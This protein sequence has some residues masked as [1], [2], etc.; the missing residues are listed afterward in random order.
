MVWFEKIWDYLRKHFP[1]DLSVIEGLTV[2]PVTID[3]EEV[4]IKLHCGAAAVMAEF[5]G[6][7]LESAVRTA[8]SKI[9]VN[10]VDS[11]PRF[12][13]HHPA[14]LGHYF[15]S[16]TV[17]GV[18]KL[19]ISMFED[20][21]DEL[22][23]L[24]EVHLSGEDRSQMRK[25]LSRA[26][27]S[28][29]T[30]ENT[31]FLSKLPIF[32]K[33]SAIKSPKSVEYTSVSQTNLAVSCDLP[34]VPI[35]QSFLDLSSLN[36]RNLASLLKIN[37]ITLTQLL[38]NIVFPDV[39]SA[40]YDADELRKL[41]TFV[42]KQY[43]SC[44]QED[45]DF[46]QTLRELAFLPK[47]DGLLVTPDRLYDPDSPLLQDLFLGE[48]NFPDDEYADAS[49]LAVLREIGL[50]DS[51]CI[52]IYDLLFTAI[53]IDNMVKSGSLA[54]EKLSRKVNSFV[55][56]LSTETHYLEEI[57]DEKTLGEML[58]GYCWVPRLHCKPY[59]Y[60]TSLKWFEDD[61]NYFKPNE[62][63]T[64]DNC[65]LV[66]AVMPVMSTSLP[67]KFLHIFQWDELPPLTL[68][69]QHLKMATNCYIAKEKGK[70]MS[71]V[72]NIYSAFCHYGCEQV[73]NEL[74]SQRID[75]WI[76]HGDGFASLQN[77]VFDKTFTDLRPY[78]FSLPEE[79]ESFSNLFTQFGVKR[80]ADL[81]KVL[82]MIKLKNESHQSVPGIEIKRDL[83][84]CVS[85]LND[86]KS[87]LDQNELDEIRNELL[88][89]LHDDNQT[90][91]TLA[92]MHE[93]TYCDTEWLRQGHDVA[94]FENEEAIK[95]VHPNI[96]NATSESLGVPTLMSRMLDAEELDFSFGQSDSLTHRLN[97]LLQ[98]YT[99]G[100]AIPK[101][102]LQN[103]DD[104]GATELK[105]LYD[106]RQN[107]NARTFLIDE[108]MAECQGPA[109]WAY[110][111]AVFTDNDFENITK[112]SGATKES[113]IE[114]IG[115]FGL[116]FN[117]VYNIT[118]V[119]S[120]VSRNNIV[121]FD[122]HTTHLGKGIK[123]KNKPGIKIDIK[124]HRKKLRR[125][126]NQ[127]KPYDDI[128]GCDLRP[129][130]RQEAY[131]ATLFRFPLRTR[132]QAMHSEISHR[133]YDDQEVKSLLNMLM[134]NANMMLLF[135]QNVMRVGIYHL[136]PKDTGRVFPVEIFHVSKGPIKIIRELAYTGELPDT[137]SDLP[138]EK[139]DFIR[140]CNI[141]RAST[142]C[143]R[144]I[145]S[146]DLSVS[147]AQLPR[148]SMLIK[149]ECCTSD[150]ARKLMDKPS[151]FVSEDWLVCSVMGHGSALEMAV[152]EENLLPSGKSLA[153]NCLINKQHKGCVVLIIARAKVM[154]YQLHHIMLLL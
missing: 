6:I 75:D 131:E 56:Y 154:K 85:I 108:G 132:V 35:S 144:S 32:E 143:I 66:G 45:S 114:K 126:R 119:P 117:A 121:I 57:V 63:V 9:G 64:R 20:S 59:M 58:S 37:S 72:T 44:I 123:N 99:D 22:L 29:L 82:Q 49:M 27:L 122:P 145:K 110:N 15:L 52:D 39:E 81:P 11:L 50:R 30:K 138:Q 73:A 7:V 95:F 133:H 96:P 74:Q 10:V 18:M 135:T 88:L 13:Q 130:S 77:V 4:V 26:T 101:E 94:D 80:S 148:S 76:W 83:N 33:L 61:A 55:E 21:F 28:D 36:A 84:I 150:G 118:D 69:V 142:E 65:S 147:E 8:L 149:I 125:L 90:R 70:Y 14:I 16:P 5:E 51:S 128:F 98:D 115:R 102:L 3:G 41:M 137:V 116:G 62:I 47:K 146:G 60:P 106:E 48:D 54:S 93:C 17:G 43:Y 97:V 124:K 53:E 2:V 68:I 40:F 24:M 140:E 107:R 38:R 42:L 151:S 112:L 23:K 120:F 86:L 25:F 109:L 104:A 87:K 100:F 1:D 105:I 12:V 92:P 34:P 113:Q 152:L 79:V 127:F 129:N 71:M 19:L 141:L 111:D 91:L 153:S 139:Q 136:P 46:T 67:P 31:S 78:I 89:P 103:A 134:K